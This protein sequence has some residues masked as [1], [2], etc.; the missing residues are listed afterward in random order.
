M[1][2]RNE[3]HTDLTGRFPFASCNGNHYIMIAYDFDSNGILAEPMKSR[4]DK[5]Y[6][7]AYQ[8]IYKE[9]KKS[10]SKPK[11]HKLDNEASK[12]V[13][14]YYKKITSPWKWYHRTTTVH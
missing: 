12:A 6:L 14:D 3:I 5:E 2:T 9:L 8:E 11:L 1:N 10:G 13:F 7:R 4:H